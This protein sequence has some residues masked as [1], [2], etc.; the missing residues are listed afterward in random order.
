MC[1][2]TAGAPTVDTVLQV[3]VVYG[4]AEPSGERQLGST[5][6]ILFN[7]MLEQACMKSVTSLIHITLVCVVDIVPF[8]FL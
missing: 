8:T 7:H 6:V 3:S 2:E 5:I 1:L 4:T